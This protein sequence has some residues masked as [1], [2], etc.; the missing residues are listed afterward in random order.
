MTRHRLLSGFIVLALCAWS[1]LAC[2]EPRTFNVNHT[3]RATFETEAPLET[4]VGTTAGQTAVSG[5]ASRT[6]SSIPR[7]VY[8]RC[9]PPGGAGS[10]MQAKF[11]AT[12]FAGVSC[13]PAGPTYVGWS[14]HGQMMRSLPSGVFVLASWVTTI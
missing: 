4:I 14:G 3:S 2:A 8:R 6:R 10:A 1:V 13:V 5:T 7:R 11:V 12:Q 9:G